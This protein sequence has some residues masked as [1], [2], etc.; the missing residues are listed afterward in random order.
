VTGT[1]LGPLDGVG[2]LGAGTAFPALELTNREVL[3]ALPPEAW[4]RRPPEGEQL[5]FLA[6]NL[7]R[8]MGVERRRWAHRVGAPLDHAGEETTADLAARAARA[9]LDDAGVEV[10]AV[11]LILVATSTPHRFTSTVSAAVGAALG[12]RAACMDTRTGCS[13]GL[14]GL[15]TAALFMHAAGGHALVIGAETFSKIIP[16]RSKLAAVALGDGAGALVLGRRPEARLVSAYLETDGA[17]GRIIS[18]DGALPPT[19]AEIARG[20]YLLS[21]A[22]DELLATVPG[23]YAQAL[24]R[25]FVRAGIT[26]S[27]VDLYVPHQTSRALVASVAAA[28]GIAGERAFVNVERHANIG[29]AGWIVALAEARAEGRCPPGTTL[30]IAAVGGGMSWGAAVLGC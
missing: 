5:D 19:E 7:G 17:L 20:G 21:G 29:A 4:D 3:L 15:T 10:A 9:A 16:P 18:T 8:G 13:G 30:A 1:L 12:A 24:G 23:K 14:F 26:G 11:S 25:A 28:A 2:V 27:E 22:P 6:D